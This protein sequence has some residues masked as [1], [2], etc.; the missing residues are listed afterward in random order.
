MV[1]PSNYFGGGSIG[2]NGK[3][4][5]GRPRFVSPLWSYFALAVAVVVKVIAVSA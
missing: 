1:I 5:W 2:L 4:R 3:G